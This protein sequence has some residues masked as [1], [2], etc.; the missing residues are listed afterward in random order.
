M[1][2]AQQN[3][4]DAFVAGHNLFLYGCAGTG[5]TYYSLALAYK[6]IL[7]Q[8]SPYKRILI[9]RSAVQGREIGF[10]PGKQ[11]EKLS[12]YETAYLQI[13][14][15]LFSRGDAWE[16]LKAKGLVEFG[17]TSFLRGLTFTDAIVLVDECENL[18]YEECRTLITR[19]GENCLMLWSG[20]ILQSDLFRHRNDYT[21]MPRFMDVLN[22]MPSY[23]LIEFVPDDIVRSG[24]VKEFILS[25]I[26]CSQETQINRIE[27]VIIAA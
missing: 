8:G 20:D 14:N 7:K 21:G 17:C 4:Q 3:T 2:Q 10:L 15:D 23:Q 25:E 27:N 18:N 16:I 19:S 1:T 13:T 9:F 5:K 6:E 22:R 24:V 11:S 26:A 12:V